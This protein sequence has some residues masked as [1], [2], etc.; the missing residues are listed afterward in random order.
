MTR[1]WRFVWF[2]LVLLVAAAVL[3][4]AR[5]LVRP[6]ANVVF[7]A[8]DGPLWDARL[9]RTRI[10]G[11]EAGDV[12]LTLA[13]LKLARGQLAIDARF[14]GPDIVG[15]ARLT[16]TLSGERRIQLPALTLN[17]FY[18]PGLGALAGPTQFSGVDIR[19][20]R[21]ACTIATGK[22]Q[23]RALA[24]LAGRPGPDLAGDV[25]CTDDAARLTLTGAREGDTAQAWLDVRPDGEAAW[26]LTYR[27]S[28]PEVAMRLRAAGF[29]QTGVDAVYVLRGGLRWRAE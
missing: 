4:P 8:V 21:N 23:S 25:A 18:A 7:S 17:R 19:F 6:N 3:T 5:V 1:Y 29:E 20:M 2:A 28:V 24:R 14:P 11:L 16:Q 9:V 12:R 22:L 27:T 15:V 26:S 10:A 13:P